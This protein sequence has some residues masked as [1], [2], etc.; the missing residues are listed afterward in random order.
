MRKLLVIVPLIAALAGPPAAAAGPLDALLNAP[1][2]YREAVASVKQT[3]GY[4]QDCR[5]VAPRHF[6][7]HAV[8]WLELSEEEDTPDGSVVVF[9]EVFPV[10][11]RVE[12]GVKGA[13]VIE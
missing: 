9:S 3:G 13:E 4:V 5:R 2:S 7:C 8:Y 6:R 1:L 12:V 10:E 11:T